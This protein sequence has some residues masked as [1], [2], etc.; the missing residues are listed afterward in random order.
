MR[1][2]QTECEREREGEREGEK[3]S[4]KWYVVFI[5]ER[6]RKKKLPKNMQLN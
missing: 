5:K 6:E 4:V 1:A 3:K 2:R